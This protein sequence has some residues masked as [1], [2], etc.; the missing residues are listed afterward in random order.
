MEY[1]KKTE[2]II[3]FRDFP[4]AFPKTYPVGCTK[5]WILI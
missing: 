3:V 5:F 2:F 1:R 4:F